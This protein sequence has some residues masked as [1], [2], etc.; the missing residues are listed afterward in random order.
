MTASTQ[1]TPAPVDLPAILVDHAEWMV[2]SGQFVGSVDEYLRLGRYRDDE[3]RTAVL[4][5]WHR[6]H[7]QPTEGA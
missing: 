4:D 7:T 1:P 2:K 5:E 6:R 3:Q